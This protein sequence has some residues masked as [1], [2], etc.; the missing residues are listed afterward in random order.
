MRTE[1]IIQVQYQSSSQTTIIINIS[2]CQ[3]L[4]VERT[5]D[6]RNGNYNLTDLTVEWAPGY[7]VYKHEC[8]DL[9]IYFAHASYD[10][11][12]T[13][14]VLNDEITNNLEGF[15]SSGETKLYKEIQ[16]FW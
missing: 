5:I 15:H 7:P 1:V 8:K 9:F 10:D 16:R 4:S 11:D 6:E 3:I 12:L 14:W 13:K 2:G